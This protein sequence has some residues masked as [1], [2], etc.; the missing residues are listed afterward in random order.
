MLTQC[1]GLNIMCVGV[2]RLLNMREIC[3]A[4]SLSLESGRSGKKAQMQE[5]TLVNDLRVVNG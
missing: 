5:E 1:I 4:V 3:W 2:E